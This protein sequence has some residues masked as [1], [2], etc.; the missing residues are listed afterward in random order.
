MSGTRPDNAAPDLDAV[1]DAAWPELQ[2]ARL[3]THL[4]VG[5]ALAIFATIFALVLA[6]SAEFGPF[7]GIFLLV[8]TIIA[9]A[10]GSVHLSGLAYGALMPAI[11]KVSG[12]DHD[13]TG[14]EK[15]DRLKNSGF[16]PV[17]NT[18][19]SEDAFHGQIGEVP[20]CKVEVDIA[21][22][23]TYRDSDGD[24]RTKTT[25]YFDGYVFLLDGLAA[26]SR[27][28][29]VQHK[30]RGAKWLHRR[31]IRSGFNEAAISDHTSPDGA[32]LSVYAPRKDGALTENSQAF[33]DRIFRIDAALPD[34]QRVFSALQSTTGTYLA[35]NTGRNLYSFG[36]LF[37][38]KDRLRAQIGQALDDLQSMLATLAILI[39]P[40]KQA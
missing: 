38:T 32:T 26:N 13:E 15:H 17:Q 30:G 40:E 20:F 37:I 14:L 9:I 29:I 28:L 27:T 12:L 6:A 3:K 7:A 5:I 34:G 35:I 8:F 4:Y 19:K 25:T 33:L 18:T 10:A 11:V 22:K 31:M 16:L 39:P 21:D 24:T 2:K 23:R 1:L 36:G